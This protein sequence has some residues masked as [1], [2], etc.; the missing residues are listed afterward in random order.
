MGGGGGPGDGH[1]S[2]G[3][4]MKGGDARKEGKFEGRQGWENKEGRRNGRK[5]DG[6]SKGRKEGRSVKEGR[7]M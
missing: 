6:R 1:R 5:K 3:E 2:S 7:K 4:G